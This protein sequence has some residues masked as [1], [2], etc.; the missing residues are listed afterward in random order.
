MCTTCT[1]ILSLPQQEYPKYTYVTHRNQSFCIKSSLYN[2]QIV[3]RGGFLSKHDW[4][5]RQFLA[6][7]NCFSYSYDNRSL[8]NNFLNGSMC[9]TCDQTRVTKLHFL[10]TYHVTIACLLR[11]DTCRKKNNKMREV[12]KIWG[13]RIFYIQNST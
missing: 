6:V 11:S 8:P 1:F 3:T 4:L 2:C 10:N 13:K 9:K 5:H 12:F 7:I